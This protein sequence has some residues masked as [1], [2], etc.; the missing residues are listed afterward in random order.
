MKL[1]GKLILEYPANETLE[2]QTQCR[3]QEERVLKRRRRSYSRSTGDSV[4]LNKQMGTGA[5]KRLKK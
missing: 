5:P 2:Q 4:S 1:T 3:K